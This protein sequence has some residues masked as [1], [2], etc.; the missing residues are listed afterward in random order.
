MSE[1][2]VSMQNDRK[3]FAKLALDNGDENGF[4]ELGL[5]Y[6]DDCSDQ[7][8]DVVKA[9]AYLLI[10]DK[11]GVIQALR[12]LQAR[13]NRISA[14]EMMQAWTYMKDL[15]DNTESLAFLRK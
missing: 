7:E 10:A 13:E 9:A 8:K 3:Y 2:K 6:F 15:I 11:L 4:Y 1:Q 12:A 5:M 14:N